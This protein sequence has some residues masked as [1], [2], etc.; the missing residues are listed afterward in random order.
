M[1]FALEEMWVLPL[2]RPSCSAV[3]R[4]KDWLV[5]CKYQK[6]PSC[7]RAGTTQIQ[8]DTLSLASESYKISS[9]TAVRRYFCCQFAIGKL[10]H[11][12]RGWL[13]QGHTR[14]WEFW[15]QSP[16]ASGILRHRHIFHTALAGGGCSPLLPTLSVPQKQPLF[17][18]TCFQMFQTP[19][20]EL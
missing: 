20:C 11:G 10:R 6:A 13:A 19:L 1:E 8:T 12:K 17:F 9:L 3:P 18:L 16:E 4:H 15:E 5:Y 14:Q 2:L 7:L